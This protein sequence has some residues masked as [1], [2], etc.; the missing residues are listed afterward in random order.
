MSKSRGIIKYYQSL[1]HWCKKLENASACWRANEAGV[2][3]TVE[4]HAK[5]NM[6]ANHLDQAKKLVTEVYSKRI[7]EA[8]T[9]DIRTGEYK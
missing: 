9:F 4:E 1:A 2:E 3:Y 7:G 6:A 5:M 8:V